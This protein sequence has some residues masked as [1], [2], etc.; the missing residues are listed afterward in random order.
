MEELVK[1]R[2]DGVYYPGRIVAI[3]EGGTFDV[4]T[5]KIGMQTNLTTSFLQRSPHVLEDGAVVQAKFQGAGDIWYRGRIKRVNA[6]GT[7]DIVYDDG[8]KEY[9]VEPEHIRF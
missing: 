2:K 7:F 5:D 8:D 1:V 9:S 6:D 4:L 3:Y